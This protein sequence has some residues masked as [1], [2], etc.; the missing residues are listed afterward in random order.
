MMKTIFA[1]L[2]LFASVSAF[3]PAPQA[4]KSKALPPSNPVFGPHVK[5]RD[6]AAMAWQNGDVLM[7]CCGLIRSSV[8]AIR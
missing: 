2:A 8:L 1:L 4:G 3:V 5:V 6:D 7:S